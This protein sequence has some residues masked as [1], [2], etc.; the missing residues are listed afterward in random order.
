MTPDQSDGLQAAFYLFQKKVSQIF[1]RL[2]LSCHVCEGHLPCLSSAQWHKA[3]LFSGFEREEL[4]KISY[5]IKI[6][7]N[8]LPVNKDDIFSIVYMGYLVW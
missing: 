7:F 8:W 1:T 6:N 2:M 3:G 5:P 4:L